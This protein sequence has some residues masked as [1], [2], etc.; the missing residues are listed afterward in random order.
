MRRQRASLA[1]FFLF[2][3]LTLLMTYPAVIHMGSGVKD[4]GDPLLNSWIISWNAKK[5]LGLDIKDYFDANI[6]FPHKRT[7]AYSE[8]LFTQSLLA[9]PVLI[10]SRNAILSYNFVLFLSF[11]TTGFGMY[12]LARHL[13][14]SHWAG[15]VAGIIFAFSPFLFGHL[16]HMQIITAG[17]IPLSFLFLHKFF[18]HE[19][20]RD[21]LL[22]TLFFVLQVLANSYYALY[23]SLFSA[24][25]II[26]YM[27]TEKKFRDW[28]F[29]VKT[30]VFVLIVVAVA[31]PFFRQYYLVRKEMG[32]FRRITAYAS[33][34]S[35]LAA[36]PLNRLYGDITAPFL[37]HEA[38]LF[39][40][41]LASVL[42][43]S[44]V[45]CALLRKRRGK[46][47]VERHILVYSVI[48]GLAFLF[49]FGP[50]GPY[51]LLYKY[52]PGFDG[53]RVASR[54]H[55]FVMFSMAVL[56][57]F[58]AKAVW[59]FLFPKKTLAL[60]A[61]IAIP[62]VILIEYLS[63]PIPVKKVRVKEDVP[64]VYRWLAEREGDFPFIELPLPE[65]GE[66]IAKIE[67]PR[68]YYS[69]YHWKKM[70][71]GYSGFFP[72]V[73]Y[74]LMRRWKD[75]P[76]EKNI[77]DLKRL[78]VRYVVIHPDLYKEKEAVHVLAGIPSLAKDMHL[79]A[80]I[81]EALVYELT[82]SPKEEYELV[83]LERPPAL[84]KKSWTARSNVKPDKAPLAFDGD[85]S[86]RWET[87]P[88]KRGYFF[89]LDLGQVRT[90]R[91][92]SLKLESKPL[93]YPRG[94]RVEVSTDRASWRLVSQEEVTALPITS[95]LRANDLSLDVIFF[96]VQA[97]YIK[98]TNTG[99]DEVYYW[100]IYEMDVFE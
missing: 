75:F 84:S 99:E 50:H 24:L 61:A 49:T 47:L 9:L 2:T 39:P 37:K 73:Y 76:L 54:W 27:V 32:F 42:A 92:F 79:I 57:A 48:G 70:V 55:I 88:Q 38:P 18:K 5:I 3:F 56:A 68:V 71:N 86:T 63:I 87:G 28:L 4:L 25:Y 26:L 29:W 52:V 17:G 13:T 60:L 43:L 82:Y 41:I 45:V 65:P 33:L 78:G 64:E 12:L 40:G 1:V 30:T 83:L 20:W 69:T 95:F 16:G 19:R 59:R 21:L 93:D 36:P 80:Q 22:F 7:L 8:H 97:R 66:R 67:C 96:P 58:G 85:L 62:L 11:I 44:G 53:L 34:K 89:E 91:G 100:S 81:E 15:L 51:I 94:Y 72:P 23:L 6:F 98:I 35:F 90:I 14:S 10:V 46:P 31:G 77:H 74:E